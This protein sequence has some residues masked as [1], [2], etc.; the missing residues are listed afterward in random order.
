MAKKKPQREL[1]VVAQ[2]RAELAQMLRESGLPDVDDGYPDDVP[3]DP[4]R[5]NFIEFFTKM[6]GEP[7]NRLW[8][9]AVVCDAL[10]QEGL[11]SS[12]DPLPAG[13]QAHGN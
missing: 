3:P 12:D 9:A 7:I 4:I 2:L 11:I 8:L 10:E 6:P 13:G 1:P 5:D